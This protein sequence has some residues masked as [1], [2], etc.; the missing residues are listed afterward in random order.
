MAY[1]HGVCLFFG[2]GMVRWSETS[3]VLGTFWK[4]SFMKLPHKSSKRSDMVSLQILVAGG[5]CFRKLPCVKV[6]ILLHG[7][8]LSSVFVTRPPPFW[9]ETGE[10]GRFQSFQVMI[11][12]RLRSLALKSLTPNLCK[13]FSGN[14]SVGHAEDLLQGLPLSNTQEKWIICRGWR[15]GKHD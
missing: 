2:G 3:L 15:W 1:R 6:P 8:T 5:F 14:C 11:L 9:G 4:G 7:A 12:P 10:N 13:D